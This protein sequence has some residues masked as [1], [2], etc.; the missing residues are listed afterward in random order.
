MKLNKETL[1]R[2]IKEEL[3]AVM[4]ETMTIP[5]IGGSITPEQQGKI[6]ELIKSGDASQ[7]EQARMLIDALDGDPSYIDYILDMDAQR[8]IPLAHA[9][10]DTVDSFPPP[11]EMTGQEVED[12]YAATSNQE[13]EAFNAIENEYS[14]SPSQR[15]SAGRNYFGTS[16]SRIRK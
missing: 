9:H 16:N 12:F 4:N 2:I 7:I 1:K 5:P 3:D 6:T 13:G 10:Q 11:E 14:K 8:I 15:K